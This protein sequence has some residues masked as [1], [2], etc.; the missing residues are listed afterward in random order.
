M[1]TTNADYRV[2][3]ASN[4]TQEP[5][6]VLEGHA[7]R[8]IPSLWASIDAYYDVG[9]ATSIDGVERR[10]AANT[11]RL[12]VGMGLRIWSGDDLTLNY[13]GV[14]ARPAGQPAA[15]EVSMTIRQVW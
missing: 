14:V 12:G 3:G 11:L 6:V 5:L 2:G 8:L 7:S 1:F 13:E 9:G 15:Q 10:N 4:L